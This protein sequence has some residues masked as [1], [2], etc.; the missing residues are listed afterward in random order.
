MLEQL[1][2]VTRV[3]AYFQ[4]FALEG[5]SAMGLHFAAV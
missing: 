5:T 1:A 3:R 2:D 4:L